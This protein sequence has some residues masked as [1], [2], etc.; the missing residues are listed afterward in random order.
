MK[1]FN[2][3]LFQQPFFWTSVCCLLALGIL[4]G[5]YSY[6]WVSPTSSP[7]TSAGAAI[8]FSG[9]NVGIG[10]SSPTSKLD[11]EGTVGIKSGN[12]LRLYNPAN[13]DY[14]TISLSDVNVVQANY[15]WNFSGSV[16]IGATPSEKLEVAGNVKITGT[17]NGIKFPDGTSQTTAAVSGTP[18][19]SPA[20]THTWTVYK[21]YFITNTYYTGNLGGVAGGTAKCNADSNKLSGKTYHVVIPGL[22]G[23]TVFTN[24]SNYVL[25]NA[26]LGSRP[27]KVDCWGTSCMYYWTDANPKKSKN[28]G[29]A[30]ANN[31][32]DYDNIT[33][34]TFSPTANYLTGG[35][36]VWGMN[37]TAYYCNNWT[38]GT[39]SYSATIY[40][41][42][43]SYAIGTF[44]VY[45]SIT[46]DNTERLMCVED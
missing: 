37:G 4:I 31:H 7:N 46:C 16:G 22:T 5:L 18:G 13:A 11:V 15:P 26:T 23:E 44:A 12:G 3:N 33:D 27:D 36:Y 35:S 43:A 1:I 8:S 40:Y 32:F 2:K 14:A 21:H 39:S 17:G 41:P 38:N 42:D 10:T 30:F 25:Y 34:T 20:Y 29:V 6:A 19:M 45:T 28:Y 9:G 24:S